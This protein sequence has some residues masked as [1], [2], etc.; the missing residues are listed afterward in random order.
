MSTPLQMA[1]RSLDCI[2]A[3]QQ[4]V[5]HPFKGKKIKIYGKKTYL[6]RQKIQELGGFWHWKTKA[7]YV[8]E[9]WKAL[10]V[11]A[12]F[13]I[14]VK[15]EAHCHEKEQLIWVTHEEAF[16]GVTRMGCGLCDCSF[17]CGDDVDIIEVYDNGLLE[18]IKKVESKKLRAMLLE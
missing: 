14:K 12:L 3:H 18:E 15:I 13:R 2:W 9:V 10:E 6:V 5:E 17:R 7:W 4:S 11:G 1:Y 8:D 16:A